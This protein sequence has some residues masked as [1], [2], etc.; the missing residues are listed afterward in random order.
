M[1]SALSVTVTRALPPTPDPASLRPP[2]CGDRGPSLT[3]T[4]SWSS[5]PHSI[6]SWPSFTISV[7]TQG[8]CCCRHPPAQERRP[9]TQQSA[10]CCSRETASALALAGQCPRGQAGPRKPAWTGRR[11]DSMPRT[12]SCH[13]TC[14]SW[15]RVSCTEIRGHTGCSSTEG[16]LA[17]S[18]SQPAT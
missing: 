3:F 17:S 16:N 7:G 4:S 8:P 9:C 1:C 6:S 11:G 18:R 14:S 12:A 2:A 15:A 10:K 13:G 5:S